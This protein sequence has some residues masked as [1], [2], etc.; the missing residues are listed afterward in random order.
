MTL[1]LITSRALTNS[2]QFC[3]KS[4]LL[5]R[6]GG[7]CAPS[8]SPPLPSCSLS[9]MHTPRREAGNASQASWACWWRPLSQN[10]SL[11]AGDRSPGSALTGSCSAEAPSSCRAV[12]VRITHC[13]ELLRIEP[14]SQ[15]RTGNVD[16]GESNGAADFLANLRVELCHAWA[17]QLLPV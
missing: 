12:F 2:L 17:S 8:P 10:I 16:A 3:V 15:P 4:E 9:P 5:Q 6:P 13:A 14:W 7:L 11:S 1:Q